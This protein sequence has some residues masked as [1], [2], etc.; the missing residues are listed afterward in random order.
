MPRT[1]RYRP[2][3]D[4]LYT[5]HVPPGD[6][7]FPTILALH[8]WGAS[9]HD[10]LGLAPTPPHHKPVMGRLPDWRNGYVAA[11]FGSLGICMSPAAGE[12]MAEMIESGR[13]PLRA[14]NLFE[15]LAP[16]A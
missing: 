16:G 3:M 10:L 7:P 1:G 2:A 5:A 9:G 15:T 8:G 14:R 11:R 12:L 13:T 6:G 4:L